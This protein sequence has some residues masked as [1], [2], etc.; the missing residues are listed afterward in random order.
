MSPQNSNFNRNIWRDLESE[1]RDL[2]D[3]DTCVKHM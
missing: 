1:I 2:D 3:R